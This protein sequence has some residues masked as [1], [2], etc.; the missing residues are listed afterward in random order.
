MRSAS[1]EHLPEVTSLAGTA[2]ATGSPVKAVI[3]ILLV[4]AVATT[5]F[6]GG[7]GAWVAMWRR[8]R[9]R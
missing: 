8:W 3:V 7:L 5:V 6:V 1:A 9:I 2:M 4:W